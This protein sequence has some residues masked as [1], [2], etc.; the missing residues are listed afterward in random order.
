MLL[1][2]IFFLQPSVFM[3]KIATPTFIEWAQDNFVTA[4]L[5][6]LAY[7]DLSFTVTFCK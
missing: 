7:I 2:Y 4:N 5:G 3:A 1:L 6:I